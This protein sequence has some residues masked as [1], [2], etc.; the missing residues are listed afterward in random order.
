MPGI[1][2][3]IRQ[4]LLQYTLRREFVLLQ[5]S[6]TYWAAG[7]ELCY[8]YDDHNDLEGMVSILCN[9]NLVRDITFNN[10]KRYIFLE[11]LVDYLTQDRT[12]V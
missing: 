1:L 12:E 6:W 10:V 5:K 3:E 4:D 8:Y 2:S 9:Y 7:N 11:E